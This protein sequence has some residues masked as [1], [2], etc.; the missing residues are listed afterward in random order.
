MTQ[1]Q[2][3]TELRKWRGQLVGT[4]R[5]Q[6]AIGR[7]CSGSILRRAKMSSGSSVSSIKMLTSSTYRSRLPVLRSHCQKATGSCRLSTSLTAALLAGCCFHALSARRLVGGTCSRGGIS[8]HS[9]VSAVASD[10]CSRSCVSV[11]AAARV[12]SLRMSSG[13]GGRGTR[14]HRS[15]LRRRGSCATTYVRP[16]R[17]SQGTRNTSSCRRAVTPT[18]PAQHSNSAAS[19]GVAEWRQTEGC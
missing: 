15:R 6:L 9:M 10:R 4:D 14:L 3:R 16:H 19:F 8:R 11:V 17:K 5:S 2:P 1:L 12:S 7:T 18:T 13:T